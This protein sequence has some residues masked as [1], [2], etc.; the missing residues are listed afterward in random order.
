M[1]V[2]ASHFIKTINAMTGMLNRM[3]STIFFDAF[4]NVSPYLLMGYPLWRIIEIITPAKIMIKPRL[5]TVVLGKYC[6]L[7]SMKFRDRA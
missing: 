7:F 3:P 2:M 6:L 1:W 5:N 4:F